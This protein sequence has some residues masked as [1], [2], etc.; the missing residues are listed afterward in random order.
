MFGVPHNHLGVVAMTRFTRSLRKAAKLGMFAI[1]AAVLTSPVAVQAQPA[2]VIATQ[3]AKTECPA[4]L[5]AQI[6]GTWSNSYEKE[7]QKV[8]EV[9][10]FRANGEFEYTVAV[11]SQVISVSGTWSIEGNV[12]DL[13]NSEGDS[14]KAF[15]EINEDFE[16][17][18]SDDGDEQSIF[19]REAK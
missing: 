19:Y 4:D 12:I 3:V 6:V 14:S 2:R 10:V 17:I 15:V 7:G 16:L 9:I 8:D 1:A 18:L 5:K 13:T 11:D